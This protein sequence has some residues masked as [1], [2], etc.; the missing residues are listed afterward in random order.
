MCKHNN[1]KSTTE[2]LPLVRNLVNASNVWAQVLWM[3]V[4]AWS[5]RLINL[6]N[7]VSERLLHE[8]ILIYYR[9]CIMVL[10]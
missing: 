10:H 2:L 3:H 8:R 9:N 6:T 4:N 5:F 1:A 7:L